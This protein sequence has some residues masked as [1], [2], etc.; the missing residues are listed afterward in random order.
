[1]KAQNWI[2][3]DSRAYKKPTVILVNLGHADGKPRYCVAGCDYGYLHTT[4]G[5]I[6]TWR[7]YF[8]AR[9]VARKYEPL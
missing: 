3:V 1:M 2:D 8:G 7:S 5:D 4:A 6:R 9:R